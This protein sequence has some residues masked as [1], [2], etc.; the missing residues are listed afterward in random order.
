[1][2]YV[3]KIIVFILAFGL[4]D[5]GFSQCSFS[6]GPDISFC[7][8][9]FVP[10]QIKGPGSYDSYLWNTGE[11]TQN[12]T[13]TT[14]GTYFCKASLYSKDLISNGNFTG[15]NTG[16]SSS[17]SIG[18][19]GPFGPL[20]VEG[21]YFITNNPGL[22]HINFPT[23]GDHTSGTGNMMVVN[24]SGTANA[25][26]WCQNFTVKPNTTYNF[27]AWIAACYAASETELP[28]LQFSINTS[29]LGKAFSPPY[30][31]GQWFPFN[32]TWNSGS[33]TTAAICIV[34]Q[35]TS[36]NGNDFAMDDI[37]FFEVCNAWDTIQVNVIPNPVV[38]IVD[39]EKLSCKTKSVKLNATSSISNVTYNWSGPNGFTSN[40]QHPDISV[41]GTYTVIVTTAN[42]CTGMGTIE[43]LNDTISPDVSA[44]ADQTLDCTKTSVTLTGSS[45]VPNVVYSWSGPSFSSSLATPVVAQAG[46]YIL[47]VINPANGCSATAKVQVWSNAVIPDIS[48]GGDKKLTCIEKEVKLSGASS[49]P[50]VTFVWNTPS[51]SLFNTPTI[52]VSATGTYTLTVVHPANGCTASAKVNVVRDENSPSVDAG[53][54]Q[55]FTC[56]IPAITLT[57]SSSANVTYLW[58]GPGGFSAAQPSVSVS[59][60]GV[61]RLTVTNVSNGCSAVDSVVLYPPAPPLQ[62]ST[63][64]KDADCYHANTGQAAVEVTSGGTKPYTF[65]W[66]TGVSSN[67][68]SSLKAG[69][70]TCIV[71]DSVGCKDTAIITVSE[72]PELLLAPIASDTICPGE[73][74]TIHPTA[75]GGVPGYTYTIR[76]SNLN[77][78]DTILT[79]SVTNS[80]SVIATDQHGCISAAR[81]FSIEVWPPLSLVV[82][83]V[84]PLCKG[85]C[86]TLT[87]N[88][89]GGT[90]NYSYTWLPVNENGSSIKVCPVI[91]TTYT[92]SLTDACGQQ[93]KFL[94]VE[95]A[96]L[97][98]PELTVSDSVGCSP[99]C[100][101]GSTKSESGTT[102]AWYVNK[103]QKSNTAEFRDCL[104]TGSYSIQI[105]ATNS[106]GCK[107]ATA[108]S[109]LVYPSPKALFTHAATDELTILNPLVHFINE[110]GGATSYTWKFGDGQQST[111]THP[112]YFYPKKKECYPVSLHAVNQY[113]CSD[114]TQKVICIKDIFTIY[115]PN[116]FSPNGD[117]VNDTFKPKGSNI[118]PRD[119]TFSIYDRWGKLVFET[120]NLDE[121]WNGRNSQGEIYL[122]D[123]YIWKCHLKDL[124]G[125]HHRLTGIVTLIR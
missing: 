6:L 82:S 67:V 18:N 40:V 117:D 98:T 71:T 100:L 121:G 76:D 2:K 12:I 118:D 101:K 46:T 7:Q 89:K 62:I 110:S 49:T 47:T 43:V 38:S 90:G 1:M 78:V 94:T 93:Q 41:A 79:P 80:Y 85:S 77:Q 99:L 113:G 119:Y 102:Y 86:K 10:V 37:C 109:V 45:S 123:I 91:T 84:A 120:T 58:T 53:E 16:F 48:T 114:T 8:G 69:N 97:P 52:T 9:K 106:A 68:I 4:T 42:G 72:P 30:T 83:D 75:S 88:G 122:M 5:T 19:G 33:N 73:S 63:S 108:D 105:E 112:T 116:A 81:S 32:A 125:E 44:G 24:G 64:E 57:G 35:N 65:T 111:D 51:G 60:A 39:P 27:S 96:P 103:K 34:N 66:N 107:G 22:A 20:S 50:G 36:L 31:I 54:N 29:L 55:S 87:A 56:L 124:Q 115:F 92:V 59:V 95:V 14:T 3:K 104:L 26:I 15:G 74:V 61:Y 21:T 11:T 70:Y 25:A 23:F 17:Y 13:V 28:K